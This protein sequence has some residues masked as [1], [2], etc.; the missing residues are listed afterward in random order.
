[1]SFRERL[2]ALRYDMWKFRH[3]F[4]EWK[5]IVQEAVRSCND[6]PENLPSQE[7]IQA[8]TK[9]TN[10]VDGSQEPDPDPSKIMIQVISHI[11]DEVNKL[12]NCFQFSM[13]ITNQFPCDEGQYSRTNLF[14]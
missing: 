13:V 2:A 1:M 11:N 4:D 7:E 3:L 6:V 12:G 5:E 10:M 8:P 14:E 9:V